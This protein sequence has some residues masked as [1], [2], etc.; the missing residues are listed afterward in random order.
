[1]MQG[2]EVVRVYMGLMLGMSGIV[3]YETIYVG[4]DLMMMCGG[5]GCGETGHSYIHPKI[6]I[7]APL[8]STTVAFN[9]INNL[10]DL[11]ASRAFA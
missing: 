2:N 6:G 8:L 10:A 11:D 5:A 4:D 7:L 1:M 3:L 9:I